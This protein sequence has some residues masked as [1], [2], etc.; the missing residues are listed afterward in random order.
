MS[1][2]L[3]LT[4]EDAK[5]MMDSYWR[6]YCKMKK[7]RVLNKVLFRSQFLV[8]AQDPDKWSGFDDVD[9]LACPEPKGGP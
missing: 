5:T 6:D 9:Q 7:D 1:N 8:A 2:F 4:V 3:L